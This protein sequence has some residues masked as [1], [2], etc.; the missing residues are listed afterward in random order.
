MPLQQYLLCVAVYY[1]TRGYIN[2]G[3][4]HFITLVLYTSIDVIV[5]FSSKMVKTNEDGFVPRPQRRKSE[6][7]QANISNNT[8][9][10]K[11][12][13]FVHR[14]HFVQTIGR[15]GGRAC[16]QP[17]VCSADKEAARFDFEEGQERY[18]RHR[19]GGPAP[20]CHPSYTLHTPSCPRFL[21][22]RGVCVHHIF[23]SHHLYMH[24]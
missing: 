19:M 6:S 20:P 15:A 21:S 22:A 5:I 12:Q 3:T 13:L 11:W 7:S 10:P 14:E 18:F 9:P 4:H 8:H 17:R 16:V 24:A 1:H 2:F 23:R